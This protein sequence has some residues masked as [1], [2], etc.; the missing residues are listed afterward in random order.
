ME[1]R[2]YRA[3]SNLSFGIGFLYDARVRVVTSV[4]DH[5]RKRSENFFYAMLASQIG[6]VISTLSL[7]K[8]KKSVLLLI[9]ALVGAAAVAF[10]AFVYLTI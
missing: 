5:Y 9:A 2:R 7:A 10:G 6:A 1:Q 8:Q 3:E 4:S